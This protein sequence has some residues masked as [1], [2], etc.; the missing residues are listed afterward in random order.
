LN[1]AG[2][3]DWA[4]GAASAA[5][6]L[7]IVVGG[8]WAYFKFVRGRTFARRA[9]LSVTPTLLRFEQQ[10]TLKVRATLRNAG[11]SK[12]PL[13]T[14]AIFIYGIF[15]VPTEDNPIATRERQ[16]GKP[17]A[18]FAAH[19]WVEA[20]ETISDEI[21]VL[22]PGSQFA[23]EHEWLAFRVECRVYEKRRR[24]GALTWTA[25]T[26]VPAEVGENADGLSSAAIVS[27]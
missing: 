9:E 17:K 10:P 23:R 16:L 27:D 7:A 24:E 22:L 5:Q 18:I 2:W 13:R 14:Q 12:L 26:I 20:Q 21:V 8:I 15:A 25:S 11:L 6:T 1:A 3:T 4:N 19:K